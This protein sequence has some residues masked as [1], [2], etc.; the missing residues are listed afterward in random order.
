MCDALTA[1]PGNATKIFMPTEM[2]GLASATGAIGE[3]FQR[4]GSPRRSN[5][6]PA[7]SPCLRKSS[8]GTLGTVPTVP[9]LAVEGVEGL[10]A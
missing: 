6:L 1:C 10:V 9:T 8:K 2:S 7:G 4:P 3:L 5:P